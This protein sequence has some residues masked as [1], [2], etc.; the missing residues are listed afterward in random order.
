M[1]MCV[2]LRLWLCIFVT[3]IQSSLN[4]N[5]IWNGCLS[6]KKIVCPYFADPNMNEHYCEHIEI[7]AHT[8]QHLS[9]TL[10][11]FVASIRK[12]NRSAWVRDLSAGLVGAKENTPSCDRNNYVLSNAF[13]AWVA[14]VIILSDVDTYHMLHSWNILWFSVIY[15]YAKYWY[16]I[17]IMHDFVKVYGWYNIP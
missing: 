14:A 10:L 13:E 17:P 9:S 4:V 11:W 1:I 7:G 8:R 12:F 2:R 6:A 15:I 5:M 16:L 3:E